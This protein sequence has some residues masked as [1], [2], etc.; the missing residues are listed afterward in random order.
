MEV[1]RPLSQSEGQ[2]TQTMRYTLPANFTQFTSDKGTD[3]ALVDKAMYRRAGY[4]IL[5]A[6]GATPVAQG[7]A[8]QSA[9]N[10]SPAAQTTGDAVKAGK[11]NS[12]QK[13]GA[14]CAPFQ[15]QELLLTVR[16]SLVVQTLVSASCVVFS[17]LNVG[18]HCVHVVAQLVNFSVQSLNVRRQLIDF[19]VAGATSQQSRTQ[20]YRAPVPV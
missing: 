8:V 3:K 20:D 18:T 15:L 7:G 19:S 5:V 9:Q 14:H 6:A 12:R 16:V 11:G 13:N 4:P 10:V 17:S 2:N 1:H